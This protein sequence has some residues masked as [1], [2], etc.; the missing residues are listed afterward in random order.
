MGKATPSSAARKSRRHSKHSKHSMGKATPSSA[1]LGKA[2]KACTASTACTAPEGVVPKGQLLEVN[3]LDEPRRLVA[4][5][6]RL[7]LLLQ[8]AGRQAGQGR[9]AGRQAGRQEGRRAGREGTLLGCWGAG[10]SLQHGGAVC[11]RERG[12]GKAACS[13]CT[14]SSSAVSHM[15]GWLAR[16]SASSSARPPCAIRRNGKGHCQLSLAPVQRRQCSTAR[17]ALPAQHPAH[18]DQL[19][20][21]LIVVW[22][23]LLQHPIQPAGM[24][25]IDTTLQTVKHQPRQQQQPRQQ[26]QH[27]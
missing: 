22:P 15:A 26:H 5:H 6:Q 12:V 10:S 9:Q 2:C 14:S 21:G 8:Q 16:S 25:S 11:A 1:A 20:D 24:R 19:A 18:L 27:Q 23:R 4:H 17:L 13:A 7:H 3:L